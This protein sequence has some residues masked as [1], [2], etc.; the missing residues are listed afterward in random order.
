MPGNPATPALFPF[1]V[2]LELEIAPL[3]LVEEVAAVLEALLEALP[4]TTGEGSGELTSAATATD[5]IE[6]G[7]IEAVELDEAVGL[8]E[9]AP[10]GP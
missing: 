10:G 8:G 3:S 6:V 9:I 4:A 1:G 5:G 2:I 7:A